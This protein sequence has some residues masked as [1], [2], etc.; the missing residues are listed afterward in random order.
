MD[1]GYLKAICVWHRR[2]GKDHT[3][4]NIMVK[5][6][7]ERVGT[8]YYVY[9]TQ[10]QGR[11]AIW[12]NT[13]KDGRRFLDFI[14]K[15]IIAGEINN[16]EMKIRFK[17]GSL[18]QIVGSD[19][20]DLLLSTNP[21]GI[22]I[23]EFSLH[24]SRVWDYLSPI[25]LEN[26]GWVIF[27]F[28]PRGYN[29][30]FDLFEMA[31]KDPLW[32]V[33]VL[34]VN[35][36]HVVS[37]EDIEQ[38]RKEGKSEE[39]IQQ[40]YYCSFEASLIGAYYAKQMTA[41][42]AEGRITMVPYEPALPVHTFWDLGVGDRTAVG[43]FQHVGMEWR[44]IDC[45]DNYGEGLEHYIKVLQQKPYVYKDHWAPHDIRVKEF[46]SG[47]TRYETAR[48]LG[49]NF[50]I[51]PKIELEDGIN[52]A[53]MALQTLYIDKNKCSMFV[54]AMQEYT[55]EWDDMRQC[56]SDNPLHDWTSDFA[57]M[58][59]YFAVSQRYLPNRYDEKPPARRNM[60]GRNKTIGAS[61][62]Y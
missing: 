4:F 25:L 21:V 19:N 16:T 45:Y 23:S 5:K 18:L 56:F 6:T 57:D 51:V 9:P 35:D 52:A 48:S 53:R 50:R 15:E 8:Y 46:G 61:I 54:R 33:Q 28:T 32:F 41:M 58:F 44:M 26:G 47:K 3:C 43:F 2:A 49:I 30:A 24:G 36:T 38:Q 22:V 62:A 55:H 39:F 12:D 10:R 40:E 60:F 11:K 59:R 42:A 29:H 31:K 13:T 20:V 14:P 27:N 34:T 7:Q 17:N 37:L 1:N